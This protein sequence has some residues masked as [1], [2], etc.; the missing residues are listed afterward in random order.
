M[1]IAIALKILTSPVFR[2]VLIAVAALGSFAYIKHTAYQKGYKAGEYRVQL[3]W[4]S[5]AAK[6]VE[7][8]AKILADSVRD[9]ERAPVGSVPD[10][11]DRS[12]G[13]KN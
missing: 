4:E 10:D 3:E 6:E 7:D 9:V 5:A 11:W 8:G 1:S 13:K 2:W 12:G